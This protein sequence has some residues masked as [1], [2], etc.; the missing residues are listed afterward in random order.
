MTSLRR[1]RTALVVFML[2]A[3][4]ACS[5]TTREGQVSAGRA[6]G[7][8]QSGLG[9][10][11]AT[12][13]AA[14]DVDVDGDGVPDPTGTVAAA[15]GNTGGG[16]ATGG[17]GGGATGG[18]A[19]GTAAAKTGPGGR[20]L[21]TD[22]ITV[23]WRIAD[24]ATAQAMAAA[25]GTRGVSGGDPRGY[26][27]ALTAHVNANGGIA[28][29]KIVPEYFEVDL[30]GLVANP[31]ASDQRSCERFTED[32][33]VFTVLSPIP[34]GQ[35]LPGCLASRGVPLILQSPEEFDQQDLKDNAGFFYLPG[36]PNMSRQQGVIV[37]ALA[38]Q[39]F[40]DGAR[41]GII[42]FDKP[43]FRRT[44]EQWLKPAL[45]A[46]GVKVV[47]EISMSSY[48]SSEQYSSAVLRMKANNVT[49]VQIVDVSGLM[50]IQFMQ[51]AESQ[52]FRPRYGLSSANSLG[53][54]AASASPNQLRRSIGVGWMPSLDVPAARDPGPT[55][56][57]KQCLDILRAAGKQMSDRVA[58][59]LAIWSCETIFFFKA[60]MERAPEHTPAGLRAAVN[61]L[62]TSYV[63]ASTFATRFGPDRYDGPSGARHLA[64]DDACSCFT[65]TAPLY[66][67][68]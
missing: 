8:S 33:R 28:G 32:T 46:K 17:T 41:L 51:H 65:Y 64:Y 52:A 23:G 62:G 4:V 54:V 22:P 25:L 35:P 39:N 20:A 24:R 47:D 36:L 61:G 6:S 15:T 9:D 68:G 11:A 56:A 27:E 50:A 63:P 26:A 42:W 3:S 18:A 59:S 38:A 66:D 37:N 7:S 49:H 43:A 14:A 57:G 10:T 44:V 58:E 5:S 67:I 12:G 40:Y 45:A 29:R 16:P 21:P 55:P 2:T 19:P 48:T 60:A 30:T 53:A 1:W 34:S 31:D 13:D